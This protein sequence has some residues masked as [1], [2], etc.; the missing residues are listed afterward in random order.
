MVFKVLINCFY[1]FMGSLGFCVLFNIRGKNLFFASL[2]GGIGWF[3]YLMFSNFG[4]SS[5]LSLFIASLSI[6]IYSEI[7]A[8]LMKT[9][10]T[11][12][13]ISAMLPLVP[14][15]GMYYTMLESVKGNADASLS[16]GLKTLIDAG[17]IAVAIVLISSL[18]KFLILYKFKNVNKKIG[19]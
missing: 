16:L 1:A 4:Y 3:V 2:G 7:F 5:T 8:R 11:T 18:S 19:K 6:S 12:Y 15:S 10:V 9:P 13:I 14:G 17:S